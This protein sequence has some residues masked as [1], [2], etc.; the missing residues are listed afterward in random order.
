MPG[1][2]VELYLKTTTNKEATTIPVSAILEIQGYYFVFVQITPELFEMREVKIGATDGLKTEILQGLSK[3]ERVV[4]KGAVH[5][6]LARGT[7]ALDA[8]S[9][10]VH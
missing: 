2:F 7:G 10:H 3:D 4:T 1:S 6:K 5:I 8:H 9:G